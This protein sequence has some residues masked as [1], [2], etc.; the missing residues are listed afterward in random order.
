VT[1]VMVAVVAT[2]TNA[3]ADVPQSDAY[4]NSPG[5][6]WEAVAVAVRVVVR[7]SV[8]CSAVDVALR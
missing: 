2:P 5:V 3:I 4:T 7:R 8:G 1:A 6:T